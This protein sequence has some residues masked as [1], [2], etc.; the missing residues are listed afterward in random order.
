MISPADLLAALPRGVVVTPSDAALLLVARLA[1]G[2]LHVQVVR[3]ES[4]AVIYR[5]ARALRRAVE[6]HGAVVT[7]ASGEA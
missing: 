4:E 2:H 3:A 7:Q 5:V 6:A 1:D